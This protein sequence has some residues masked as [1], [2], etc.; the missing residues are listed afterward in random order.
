MIRAF[1][2][3]LLGYGRKGGDMSLSEVQ[4]V[5]ASI[6]EDALN[7][8]IT[9]F[10]TDRPRHLVYGSPSFV[11]VTTVGETN[12]DAIPF[13]GVPGGIQWHLQL[14][15]PHIDLFQQSSQLPPE[16]SLNPGEFSLSLGA[17]LCIDC[18]KIRIRPEPVRDPTKKDQPEDRES[19][20]VKDERHPERELTCFK[21]EVFAVGHLEMAYDFAGNPAI[22]F[23]VDAV[24]IVD[25][26]PDE[27]ESFL[28]CLL[29]IILQAV[30]AD[31][32]LPLNALRIG[33]FSLNPIV[34]PLI[35]DDH[36]KMRGDFS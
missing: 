6:H 5:F 11:P 20:G 33:A 12:I 19:D 22:T 1:D 18:K 31:V 26:E 36:I 7:D 28:E 17:V 23:A 4:E 9:A 3:F 16:L 8:L 15:V 10:F 30:M 27:L 13:P 21:L 34:G 32:R 2:Q 35:E 24:E 14:T 29:F 25:I